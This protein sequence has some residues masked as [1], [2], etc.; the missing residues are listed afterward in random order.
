MLAAIDRPPAPDVLMD[1]MENPN[2]TY[3]RAF[4]A[5]WVF[6]WGAAKALKKEKEQ[7]GKGKQV[8]ALYMAWF[9]DLEGKHLEEIAQRFQNALDAVKT[10]PGAYSLAT[11]EKPPEGD[12]RFGNFGTI[13][14]RPALLIYLT[15]RLVENYGFE[16][17][18][19]ASIS[20]EWAYPS[21]VAVLV[22]LLLTMF[23]SN[24]KDRL[25]TITPYS[26]K[27]LAR[28]GRPD[29]Y[30]ATNPQNLAFYACQVFPFNFGIDSA[31][32]VDGIYYV[33]L[34]SIYARYSNLNTKSQCD[35]NYPLGLGDRTDFPDWANLASSFLKGFDSMTRV[36]TE[37][38]VFVTRGDLYLSFGLYQRRMSS[39]AY[40]LRQGWGVDARLYKNFG[41]G[42]DTLAW[43]T[44]RNPSLVA[45]KD[46][47]YLQFTLDTKLGV[48]KPAVIDGNPMLPTAF[49]ADWGKLTGDFKSRFDSIST[50]GAKVWITNGDQ[51]IGYD[52]S[53]GKT[54]T[55]QERSIEPNWGRMPNIDETSGRCTK[56]ETL[57]KPTVGEKER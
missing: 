30:A 29:N 52:D 25:V 26:C 54:I 1:Q 20:G 2:N 41:E 22:G 8:S 11:A 12:Y 5:A 47:E 44:G 33:T 55:E 6:I 40:D 24:L 51:Y 10:D 4:W 27:D 45:T 42:F 32:T 28:T 19:F 7:V 17:L 18:P 46:G 35:P 48:A 38:R 57:P 15:S 13:N 56:A 21:Q 37:D 34:G 50:F 49:G 36:G 14:G 31:L 53:A 3:T 16:R 23:N 39:K 9:K 43:L